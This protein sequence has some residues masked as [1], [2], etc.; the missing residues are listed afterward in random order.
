[1]LKAE[2]IS[3]KQDRQVV[4]KALDCEFRPGEFW[5]IL[6]RN[7]TG[8][9]TLLHALS[10]LTPVAEGQITVDGHAVRHLD[11]V[12]RAQNL[13][14]L[15]QEQE[16]S[17][18]ISV[19]DAVAMGRYPWQTTV[20]EDRAL[21]ERMLSLCGLEALADRSIL[22]LSGGERRKV[23]IATCLAQQAGYLLLDEPLNHLD[24]VYK[25]LIMKVF[26]EYSRERAVIMVCHDTEVV[27]AHCSHVLMILEN[28]CYLSGT[29][30]TMLTAQNLNRLFNDRDQHD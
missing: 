2:H 10:G 24:L 7:G 29:S 14:L 4:I 27:R 26:S 22:Q 19:A 25:K 5:A 9:T 18:A 11:P 21:T 6:G 13:S 17:L 16:P 1:M 3:I 20:A 15:L 8:K 28:D 23:E 12:S 30:A